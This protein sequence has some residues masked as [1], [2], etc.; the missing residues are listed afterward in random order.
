MTAPP[1]NLSWLQSENHRFE[2]RRGE[3]MKRMENKSANDSEEMESGK[4]SCNI[5]NWEENRIE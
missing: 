3:E 2:K 5:E 1:W 4:K